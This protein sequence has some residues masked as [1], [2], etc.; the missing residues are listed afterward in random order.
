MITQRAHGDMADQLRDL[1]VGDQSAD[2]DQAAVAC[3]RAI[4]ALVK[5][6]TAQNANVCSRFQRGVM[7]AKCRERQY[8]G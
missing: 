2:G 1:T 4:S 6:S 8:A 7:R 5:L 3:N